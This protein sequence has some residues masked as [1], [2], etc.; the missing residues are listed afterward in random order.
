MIRDGVGDLRFWGVYPHPNP[1]PKGEG[2]FGYGVSPVGG[3]S[4]FDKL[5]MNE[6]RPYEWAPACVS[7]TVF[8]LKTRMAIAQKPARM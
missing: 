4:S 3:R 1:P 8:L 5:R 6:C 7:Q 2:I